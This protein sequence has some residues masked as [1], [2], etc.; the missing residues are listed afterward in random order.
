MYEWALLAEPY[1]YKCENAAILYYIHSTLF[2]LV[3]TMPCM[4]ITAL[5]SYS[6]AIAFV[7][8]A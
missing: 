1:C 8:Y 2:Y 3:F 4:G 5:T 7:S 6:A